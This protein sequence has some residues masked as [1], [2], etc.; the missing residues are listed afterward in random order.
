MWELLSCHSLIFSY[1]K[2]YYVKWTQDLKICG[3]YQYIT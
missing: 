1:F 2:N 3:K